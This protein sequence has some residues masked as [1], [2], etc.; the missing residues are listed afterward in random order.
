MPGLL[1]SWLP[2][3]AASSSNQIFGGSFSF[4]GIPMDARMIVAAE[5]LS[6]HNAREL[7]AVVAS[8]LSLF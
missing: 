6:H 1:S 3:I 8:V 7:A 4:S 5:A 2:D